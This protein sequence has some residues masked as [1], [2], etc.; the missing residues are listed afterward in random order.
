MDFD[1][2]KEIVLENDRVKLTPMQPEDWDNLLPVALADPTLVQYSPSQIHSEGHLKKYIAAALSDRANHFRYAFTIFDKKTQS[3]AG[4]TSFGNIMNKD[5]RIEIGWTWIGREFQRTGLNRACKLLL[6]QYVFETLQ[7]ERL[8]FRTDER[9]TDSRNAIEKIG[10]KYEG[11]LRSHMQLPDGV[12]RN[13]VC[14]SI[15]KEEWPAVKKGLVEQV[16]Q[17]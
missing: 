10:G 11:L 9:N 3:Y 15:L 2:S 13:T 4:S 14:Y 17:V 12:R 7:F 6:M 5:K 8:E 1:F 16:A